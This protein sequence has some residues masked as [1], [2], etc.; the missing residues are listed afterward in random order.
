MGIDPG[1]ASLGMAVLERTPQGKVRLLAV[2]VLETKK[3]SKKAM[4]DLRVAADDQR[5]LREFWEG[6]QRYLTE[7]SPK[8]MGVESYAPWPGQMGGNAWK[9]AFAYQMAV[10]AGW[11]HGLLPMTFRP[12]D[13][14]RRLLGKNSGTK[15][16]V[17]K[18]LAS[19]VEGFTEALEAI[20]KTKR[21]HAADAVGHAYLAMEEVEKMRAMYGAF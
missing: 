15:G 18:A 10:C 12:D 11:A 5:R 19:Q 7:F 17:E 13:L 2:R 9:V 14:K 3:G 6:L 8:A 20:S 4:R 21:E 16:D 1:F